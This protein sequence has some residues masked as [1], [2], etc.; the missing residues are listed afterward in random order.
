MYMF[1][2]FSRTPPKVVNLILVIFPPKYYYNVFVESSQ[3]S[4][5]KS[6]IYFYPNLFLSLYHFFTNFQNEDRISTREHSPLITES[7]CFVFSLR[8]LCPPKDLGP[9][10]TNSYSAKIVIRSLLTN[11]KRFRSSKSF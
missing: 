8:N 5:F 11:K 3:L 10:F 9:Y 7:L 6:P 2:P 1:L 4:F